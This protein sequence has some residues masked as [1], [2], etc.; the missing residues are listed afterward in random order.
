M[1]EEYEHAV[2][3]FQQNIID[4]VTEMVYDGDSE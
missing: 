1:S 2:M 3:N 4:R